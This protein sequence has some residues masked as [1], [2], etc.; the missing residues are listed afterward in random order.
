MRLKPHLLD[1]KVHDLNGTD[2]PA[3]KQER[4]HILVAELLYGVEA[5]GEP[6]SP[7]VAKAMAR[8]HARLGEDHA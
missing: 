1:A 4:R 8:F 3:A 7:S 5:N 2:L 6:W